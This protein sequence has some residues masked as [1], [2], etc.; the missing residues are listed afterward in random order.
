MMNER[1]YYSREAEERAQQERVTLAV[2]AALFGAAIATIAA[3]LL[4]PKPKPSARKQIGDQV[5]QMVHDLR[6]SVEKLRDDMEDRLQT[7]RR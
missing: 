5:E 4:A 1:T 2:A 7:V 6:D 3:I